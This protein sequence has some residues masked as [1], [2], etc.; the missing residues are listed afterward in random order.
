MTVTASDALALHREAIRE[1]LPNG[2]TLLVRR[3]TSAP[4][5]AIVTYVKAGYFDE[6]DDI[7]G[8]AHVLEHMFFKG[9][10]ERGVGAI[11]RETKYNGGYLNAHTIYDHTSYYTVLPSTAFALGLEIQFDAYARSIIDAD[12]LARELEVIIQETKRKRDTP[13]AVAIE[14]LYALLHDRHRIR[15]WRIGEES[16]LRALTREQLLA[17][18]QRWY[19][20]SNTILS[21]VGD[22]DPDVV[23]R[24]VMARH[25]VLADER[26]VRERGPVELSAPGFRMRDSSGDIAQQQLAFGWRAPAITHADAAA[27]DLAAVAL[28]TGRA[29][30][31]YRAVR[32]RQLASSVSAWNYTTG[33]IGVFVLHA[34]APPIHAVDA[35]TQMWRETQAARL[36]G[37]RTSEV[38]RA[39]RITEARWLRRLETMDGQATYLASW[40]ADGGL[41]VAATYYD[42]VLTL[43]A[44]ALK[45]AVERHLDP[46]QVSIIS[47]RPHDAPPLWDDRAACRRLLR[48][49]EG[50]GSS[51]LPPLDVTTPRDTVVIEELLPDAIGTTGTI[52]T[53]GTIGVDLGGDVEYGVH[54]FRTARGI[55]ILILPLAGVPLINIGVFQRGGSCLEPPSGEGLARLTAHSMLKG[56]TRRS[57]ARIAEATEEL[58]AS[59]AVTAGLESAGWSLSVPVRHL[60]VAAALLADVVQRP[61]FPV[62]GVETERSLA[63]AEIARARDDMYR[64]PMRLA[65]KAAYGSHPYARAVIGTE[66]SLATLDAGATRDFHTRHVA[67]G[68]TVIALVGDVVP[69][70]AARLLAREFGA[71]EWGADDSVPVMPWPTTV[72]RTS[73]TRDKQQTAL[74]LLFPG[75]SRRDEGRF[76]AL[77]LSAVV[78]GLGGRFFEQLR[79]RQSLAYTVSAFPIERQT[80]GAFAAYI[81]TSPARETEAR[82]GLLLEFAK[83]QEQAPS[84]DELDRAR[85]Y[86]VGTHAISRQSG[87]IV[88]GDM[89]NAWLFGEGLHDL[90][91]VESRIRRVSGADVLA[92]ARQYFDPSNVVE[93]VVRG[94]ATAGPSAVALA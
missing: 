92:L 41:E 66:T 11:A 68:N 74:A 35:A 87:A 13:A 4:V 10:P 78:S 93:A 46:S 76:A 25:G 36:Y 40:E 94:T 72:P 71:L 88:L 12:E 17:F 59:I 64:W 80:S 33:D 24:E 54:V 84:D 85:R 14:S 29:S 34:E 81:A 77:V 89:V 57:G 1:V 65:T 43:S 62:D 7:V 52:G 56:T 49:V 21:V 42:R 75:P 2:L 3:D 6:S 28:G 90:H 37:F 45:S 51:V 55:P 53:I 22:V 50:L 20:P 9:T 63:V 18:Y 69:G 8:I 39:Q 16:A 48:E 5:V 67:T 73:E 91:D 31:L 27:L 60:A 38:V 86:L 15:R 79:D 23:R 82:A 47:Y 58:G 30:R 19:R 44:G 70:D 26:L 32:E 83:L 61:T